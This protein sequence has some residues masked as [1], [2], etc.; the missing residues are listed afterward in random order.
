MYNFLTVRKCLGALALSKTRIQ[1]R[2]LKTFSWI[3]SKGTKAITKGN[4][5]LCCLHEVSGMQEA[6]KA[7]TM[8]MEAIASVAPKKFRQNPLAS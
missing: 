7:M 4:K 3:I 1:A 6:I 2:T 5:Y 8:G